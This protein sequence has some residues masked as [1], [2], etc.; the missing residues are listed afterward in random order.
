MSTLE[1]FGGCLCGSVRFRAQGDPLMTNVCHCRQC[2]LRTGSAFGIGIYYYT[3]KVALLS[4]K[5]ALYEYESE[6]GNSWLFKRC[7]HCGTCIFTYQKKNNDRVGITGGTFDPPTFWYNLT[8][9]TYTRSK[10]QF[11]SIESKYSFETQ[12]NY[13]RTKLVDSRLNGAELVMSSS[14]HYG[15]CL[16]G[17][18]RFDMEGDPKLLGVCHCRYCQLRTGSGFG[19]SA[20]CLKDRFHIESGK[21]DKYEYKSDK[22]IQVTIKRCNICGSSIFW[23][24]ADKN[25]ENLVVISGGTFDP[26]TFWTEVDYEYFTRSKAHFCNIDCGNAWETSRSYKKPDALEARLVGIK[27][28]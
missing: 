23:T 26:P 15:G 11:C 9:Q 2:Q 12:P 6:R 20:I 1:H 19:V 8:A 17:S 4:G 14:N 18:V 27:S 10:A 21:F 13:V 25:L 24:L 7:K 22:D 5:L 28:T 16:C 3:D